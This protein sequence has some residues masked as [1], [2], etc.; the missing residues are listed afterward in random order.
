MKNL[1]LGTRKGLVVYEYEG[2]KWNYLKTH[3]LGI[4][5]SIVFIDERN[6][7]WW[8]CLDHGHWGCKM[9]FSTDKGVSWKEVSAPA[10][11]AGLKI[12][13]NIPAT[14]SYI[15][16]MAEGGKEYPKRLWLGTVP[17]GLFISEDNGITWELNQA[18]WNDPTRE[19]LWFGGG[20]DHPGIH[21]IIV[22]PKDN[23]HI[24]IGIS[25]A[26]VFETFDSGLNWDKKNL[27]MR[28]DFLPSIDVE[29]GFDPHIVVPFRRDVNILWQQNHCGVYKS[30]NAGKKWIEVSQKDGPVD[31][32]FA[33]VV[34]EINPDQAWVIPM[35]SDEQRIPVDCALKVFRTDDGGE[36]WK[37]V[38]D[39]LPQEACF[40]IVY[41]HALEIKGEHLIFG[42]ST[43][44]VYYSDN[45]G[46]N[47]NV[48]SNNLAMVY[49]TVL[50]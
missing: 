1:L 14:T 13:E 24:I 28:A 30:Y 42:T 10:Y 23:D 15:W 37:D 25:C 17:G 36:S 44:N 9:H 47:W 41:R 34:S 12:K 31:V 3:F 35:K 48:L 8:V 4:P 50:T 20:F 45:L 22:D 29:A 32:G 21:S 49:S 46:N 38:S 40:D 2:N 39:G 6:G 19:K 11:P 26:G 5:V 16:A 33:C 18:L 27:G 43:G 7:T